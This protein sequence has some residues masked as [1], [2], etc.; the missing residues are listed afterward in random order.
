MLA[1]EPSPKRITEEGRLG[2]MAK[3]ATMKINPDFP[4]SKVKVICIYTYDWRDYEDVKRIREELRKIGIARKIA[5]KADEDTV[6]GKYRV[7]GT[8][9]LSKYYE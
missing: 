1:G 6:L 5:Y 2:D 3:A 4:S 7:A 9:K 8:D